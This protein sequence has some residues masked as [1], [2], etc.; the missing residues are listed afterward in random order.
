MKGSRSRLRAGKK[1]TRTK[2]RPL[3]GETD[4]CVIRSLRF[5]S[6]SFRSRSY[7]PVL[8]SGAGC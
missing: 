3:N 5:P 8:A 6:V 1:S 7:S 2:K 4:D